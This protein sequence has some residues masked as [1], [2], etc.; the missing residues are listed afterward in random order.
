MVNYRHVIESNRPI[1]DVNSHYSNGNGYDE[2]NGNAWDVD[3]D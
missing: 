2:E 1:W 3:L